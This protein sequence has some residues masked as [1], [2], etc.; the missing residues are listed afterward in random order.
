MAAIPG[1]N[2][3]AMVVPFDDQDIFATHNDKYGRGGYR[4]ANTLAERDAITVHRRKE[5]MLVKVLEDGKIYELG[6][7]ET[8]ADWLE[9][10]TSGG[11]GSPS[12][13][14]L[15]MSR[16]NADY[17]DFPIGTP[18]FAYNATGVRKAVANEASAAWKVIGLAT[19]QVLAGSNGL[20]QGEGKLT[21]TTA[22][23]DALTGDVGGLVANKTYFLHPVLVG[24]ITL[25]PPTADGEY[26]CRIGVA[27]SPTELYIDLGLCIK[28]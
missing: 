6:P 1:T 24:K 15:R 4:V 25:I 9:F 23:W 3:A 18:V 14:L 7:G 20:F 5:G 19:S 11:G 12:D 17:T 13:N 2:V 21:A 22:E 26:V 16:Q 8:N 10:T 27:Y 28:L